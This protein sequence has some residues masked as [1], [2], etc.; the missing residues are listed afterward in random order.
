M[1]D[2][3]LQFP[4]V[5]RITPEELLEDLRQAIAEGKVTHLMFVTMGPDTAIDCGL[6]TSPA[7]VIT[8]MNQYQRL[9]IEGLM[10]EKGMIP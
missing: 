7:H 4:G 1:S 10:R 3:I 2:N 9:K 8:Y 5:S 6:T